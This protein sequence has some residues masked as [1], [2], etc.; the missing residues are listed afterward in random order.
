MSQRPQPRMIRRLSLMTLLCIVLGVAPVVAQK[1]IKKDEARKLIAAVSLLELNK[2][3][4]TIREISPPQATAATVLAGVKLAFRFARDGE[5]RWRVVEVRTGDRQWE[6]FDLLARSLGDENISP[7]RLELETLA[8]ELD[9][10]GKNKNK[11]AGADQGQSENELKRGALSVKYPAAA[12]SALLSSAVLEAEVG[13]AVDFNRDARGRWQV[14]R[15]R[16]GERSFE[17][18]DAFAR[19]LETEKQIR[20]RADLDRLAAAL[21]AYRREH[22]F[23]VVAGSAATLVDHLNPRY[24][25]AFIRVDPWHRPYEYEGTRERFTLRSP[26]ADGKANTPDDITIGKG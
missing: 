18:F 7:A 19:L 10:S 8:A 5:G 9:A 20:A 13:V 15:I 4:V 2:E 21:E 22:G 25:P 12:L 26:G 24:T 23:Y 11:A 3:A 6:S 17:G 1:S 14:A 16:L